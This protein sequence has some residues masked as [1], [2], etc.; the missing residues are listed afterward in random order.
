M[1][2]LADGQGFDV[3]FVGDELEGSF[4]DALVH[5]PGPLE[6]VREGKFGGPDAADDGA[7]ND[8]RGIAGHVEQEG[9]KYGTRFVS[10]KKEAQKCYNET[11]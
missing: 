4:P 11:A 3:D 9:L 6:D 10:E 8:R 7:A 2:P 1:L 5:V